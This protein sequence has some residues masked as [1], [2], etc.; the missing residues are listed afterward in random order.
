LG[1]TM[2]LRQYLD[3]LRRRWALI[4]AATLIVAVTAGVTSAM[5][6]PV[7][8]AS[9]EVLLRPGDPAEQLGTEQRP[10]SRNSAESDRY[11]SAQLGII[12]SEPVAR[13]AAEE[14][15]VADADLGG[16]R[17]QVNA[18]QSGATD[19]VR[20]SATDVDPDRAA[21]VADAFAAAYIE[22]RRLNAV[23]GL[24]RALTEINPKLGELQAQIA[25]LDKQIEADRA[26]QE[27]EW[28]RRNPQRSTPSTKVTLPI[29]GNPQF[30]I[31]GTPIPRQDFEPV[32]NQSLLAARSAAA[33][34]YQS[35][36]SQQQTLL[37]NK[38][39]KKGESELIAAAEAPEAPSSPKP[40]RD[41]AL[42]LMVGLMLGLGIAFLREQLDD[43]IRSREDVTTITNL[44]VLAELPIDEESEKEPNRVAAVERPLGAFA[45]A[46]R[47]LRTSLSFL[48]VDEPLRRIVVTSSVPGDGKSTVASNLGAVYA[49][50]GMKAILVSADLRRP[51]QEAIF[52]IEPCPGLSD[53]IADA[54]K[55]PSM[56]GNG[57][58]NGH[59]YG[60][61][62]AGG[63][64]IDQA[65]LAK[66]LRPTHIENLMVLPSGRI[67][68]NPAELLASD[69]TEEVLAALAGL[70]DVVIID[71]PPV[72][73]V[74][75]AA[76]LAA[77]AD[78]VVLVASAAGTHKGALK[79]ATDTL[80]A[81]HGRLLGVVLNRTDYKGGSSYYGSY[82][83][84][85]GQA[86][87]NKSR[88]P[89]KR[90]ESAR[91]AAEL[92]R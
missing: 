64:T 36:Y 6:T 67:P 34:Q 50:A 77:K 14:L 62:A 54:A 30:E 51:R 79:H 81:S 20:V 59:A 38:S 33:D 72:L 23:S 78:G 55:R 65:A 8:T 29:E 84:Y 45:E 74:T 57:N 42:G 52:G 31:P 25:A 40:K 53:V 37:V 66:A 92:G 41:A 16:L 7:Y 82:G 71:C 11:L 3:I 61:L 68:P 76:V 85:Y 22:N 88:L 32:A 1:R 75:D 4:V 60:H 12:E 39:L 19:V 48:G 28:E 2:E 80:A 47:G 69:R 17:D 21:T 15:G 49:Q 44:P 9:A 58:G 27:K 43:R 10:A 70:A 89:W 13:A 5:K 90:K 86:E 56:N 91:Q 73:A 35:L 83:G 26:K 46:A 63:A 87:E 24:E 18:S